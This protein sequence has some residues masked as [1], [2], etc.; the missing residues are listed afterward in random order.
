VHQN[1]ALPRTLAQGFTLRQAVQTDQAALYRICLLTGASG[2]DATHLHDDPHLLG[3]YYAIPY[4]ELQPD[5]AFVIDGAEGVCGYVLGAR[6]SAQ[7]YARMEAEWL[8][9]LR[10][11][12]PDPGPDKTRWGKGDWLRHKIHHEPLPLYASLAS[13]PSHLHIDLL[14]AAQGHGWGRVLIEHLFAA[15]AAQ[16]SPGVHLG[17]ASDNLAAQAFYHKL[18]FA[19]IKTPDIPADAVMLARALP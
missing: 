6:D 3:N 2:Q 7:F 13:H 19:R 16:G 8:A 12:L 9:P 4:L 14:P 15:L 5:L 10:Q 18:G 11:T 17:V 1:L